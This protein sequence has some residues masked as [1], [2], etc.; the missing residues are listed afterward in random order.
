MIFN[1]FKKS[2]R[3]FP[4]NVGV[5]MTGQLGNQL[6]GLMV[7]YAQAKRLYCEVELNFKNQPNLLQDFNLNQKINFNLSYPEKSFIEFKEKTTH[8]YDQDV[9]SVSTGTLFTGYFQNWK[10]FSNLTKS[11]ISSLLTVKSK[12]NRFV[13]YENIFNTNNILGI[14]VRCYEKSHRSYHGVVPI[15]YLR[16]SI[17]LA[18]RLDSF[19]EI[20]VFTDDRSEASVLLSQIN[21]E[22]SEILDNTKLTSA[23]ETLLLMSKS[24]VFIGSNS[25]Y[26]WW[27][28]F[29]CE[30]EGRYS[31]FPRP[32]YRNHENTISSQYLP[33]WITLGFADW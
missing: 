20:V 30:D 16:K 9:E 17:D 2:N 18:T 5:N 23:S 19:D 12:S 31:I 27:S 25:S 15:E 22:P 6:F 8:L 33:N 13:E 32:W 14:H 3:D 26:S 29:L 24:R 7:G 4:K 21:I 10:Y 11:E 1:K 28:A